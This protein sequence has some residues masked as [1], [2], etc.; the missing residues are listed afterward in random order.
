MHN[1][2][3]QC[4]Q[5]ACDVSKQILLLLCAALHPVLFHLHAGVR[6]RLLPL[7]PRS[8][9][10]SSHCSL[11]SDCQYQRL[12]SSFLLHTNG[13]APVGQEH[14]AYQFHLLWPPVPRLLLQQ[15]SRH[16]V[17]GE[18]L[19]FCAYLSVGDCLWQP[20]VPC[21][22][23]NAYQSHTCHLCHLC[24]LVVLPS[25]TPM[26]PTFAA[27]ATPVHVIYI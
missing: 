26:C 5:L 12:Y 22:G 6:G 1:F 10:H 20:N 24:Y 14:P 25:A 2:C 27:K 18:C 8:S 3:M 4:L 11:R 13:G 9:V 21:C 17:Y 15:H 16:C 23:H 7:Q 19:L